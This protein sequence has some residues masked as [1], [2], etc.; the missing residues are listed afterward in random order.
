MHLQQNDSLYSKPKH[1]SQP[2]AAETLL[3]ESVFFFFLHTV[4]S[5]FAALDGSS[6]KFL[7]LRVLMA[8][9]LFFISL[10]TE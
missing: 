1:P 5:C 7:L 6:A 3:I 9:L 4:I 10:L 2:L 8:H